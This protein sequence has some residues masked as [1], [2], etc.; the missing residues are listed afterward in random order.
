MD[1]VVQPLGQLASDPLHPVP[2]RCPKKSGDCWIVL[3]PKGDRSHE[4][5]KLLIEHVLQANGCQGSPGLPPGVPEPDMGGNG[6]NST[7]QV[8][9]V[10]WGCRATVG[11]HPVP[12]QG[13]EPVC[14][15]AGVAAPAS[16]LLCTD[17]RVR[18]T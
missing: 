12:E 8:H 3:W 17:V 4:Q 9:E 13:S 10:G 18:R 15:W 6:G 11:G 2:G 7:L 5:R 14:A 16:S 1:P